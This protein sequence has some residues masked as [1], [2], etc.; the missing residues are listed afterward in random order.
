MERKRVNKYLFILFD[1]K[2]KKLKLNKKVTMRIFRSGKGEGIGPTSFQ[3]NFLI[4]SIINPKIVQKYAWCYCLKKELK[5]VFWTL[6]LVT[7]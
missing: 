7:Q 5:V 3:N 6:I 2:T 4:T 1:M